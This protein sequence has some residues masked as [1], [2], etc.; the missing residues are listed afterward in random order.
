MA[1]NFDRRRLVRG[2]AGPMVAAAVI[3]YFGLSA[4]QGD[5][6]VLRIIQLRQEIVRADDTLARTNADKAGLERRV[7]A[8]RTSAH[9]VI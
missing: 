3:A 8:L 7:A 5:R 9:Q 1:L 2:A 6:G 4:F